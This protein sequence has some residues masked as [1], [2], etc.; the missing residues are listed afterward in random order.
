MIKTL[1]RKL[2]IKRILNSELPEID[3]ESFIKQFNLNINFKKM[4]RFFH[5]LSQDTKGQTMTE[6]ALV[7]AVMA[8]AVIGVMSLLGDKIKTIFQSVIDAI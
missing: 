7:L 6:Y 8:I 4:K 5:R 2:N 1:K 3:R